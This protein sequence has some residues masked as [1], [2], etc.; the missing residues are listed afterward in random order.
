MS[1]SSS[2]QAL[3]ATTLRAGNARR[4]LQLALGGLWLV[5]AALQYQPHMFSQAFLTNTIEP[6]A[7]GAPWIVAHPVLLAAHLMSHH[8]ALY[9]G[10][11]ATIQVLIAVA[12]F[13]R[14]LLE[15]G[16]ALS[17]VWGVGVWW[18]AEGTGGIFD[19]A[20]P[21]I[22]APGAALLYV[23]I[24]LFAWPRRSGGTVAG[25]S[26]AERGALGSK[27][28]KVIWAIL[29]IGL[30]LLELERANRAPSAVH[31]AILAM[32]SGEPS[33]LKAFDGALA[34][35]AANHGLEISIVLA[36]LF[37]VTA[38]AVFGHRT[39]KLSVVLGVSLGAVIWLVENLGGIPTGTATDVNTGLPLMLLA[40]CFWP[41][42][43]DPLTSV[44]PERASAGNVHHRSEHYD[45]AA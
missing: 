23:L 30:A 21:L 34:V 24:A 28:P 27:C 8:I 42:P 3:L 37:L 44:A 6:A 17:V 33:W 12:I 43:Q 41:S 1:R 19:N 18:L 25:L 13:Y 26:V 11:F 9:N 38:L 39:A 35:P 29:W 7:S 14:P 15:A 40:A 36:S 4:R 22:G 45:R 20:S 32:E 2:P 31:G 10:V 5:D 16:L